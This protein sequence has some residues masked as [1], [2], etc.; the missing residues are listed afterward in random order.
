MLPYIG[1]CKGDVKYYPIVLLSTITK[2]NSCRGFSY[3]YNKVVLI[4]VQKFKG[5]LRWYFCFLP[6]RTIYES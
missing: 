4:N 1:A 6:L 5:M 3:W 2:S